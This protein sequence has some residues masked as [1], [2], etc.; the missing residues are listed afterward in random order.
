MIGLPMSLQTPPRDSSR[1][2][3]EFIHRLVFLP[4]E[5]H[6]NLDGLL[7]ELSAA[8][9]ATAAGLA[10]FPDGAPLCIHPT[11]ID[12]CQLV[13]DDLKSWLNQQ[14]TINNPQSVG[15]V[16]TVPRRAGGSCLVTLLGVPER[17]GW[18]LWLEDDGRATWSTSEA[19]LLALAGQALTHR[20]TR[21]EAQ[22]PWA[23]QLDRGIR[24]QRMETAANIVRRLAHD[25]GN[26]LTGI[27][28]FSE[29][30]LADKEASRSPLRDYLGEVH[31]SAQSGA[32]YTNQLRL[33]ARRHANSNRSCNLVNVLVELCGEQRGTDGEKSSQ[34]SFPAGADVQVKLHLPDDLP[35]VALESEALR[36]VL[37]IVLDNAREAS[38][39][40]GVIDVLARTVQ[41]S[42]GEA[43]ALFGEVRPGKHLEIRVADNGAGLTPE[44]QRQLFAE[45]FFSTK[46]RKRG[47]GLAI[48]YGILSAYRGGLEL[49]PRLEGGTIARL[50][51]PVAAVA[52]PSMNEGVCRD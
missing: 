46:S 3:L 47:F 21:D 48:A 44:V 17:G 12:D 6:P 45:P 32:Q 2:A 39:G 5:E 51:V 1:S 33:F 19:G 34:A 24:R 4:A 9:A 7:E 52:G 41:V 49:L 11:L 8:F 36:Q 23:V 38:A 14:S 30:A 28:G 10:T 35:D 25:F 40:A 50:I 42:A 31:R 15:G 16:R 18:L 20:L 43:G 22:T 26:V 13:I 29:L 37:T 27:L